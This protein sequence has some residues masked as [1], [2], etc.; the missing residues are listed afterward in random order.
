MHRELHLFHPVFSKVLCANFFFIVLEEI[1]VSLIQFNEE[2]IEIGPMHE[3]RSLTVKLLPNV[4]ESV[5]V[6]LLDR[7]VEC[8]S[9]S[10]ERV[11]NDSYEQ[12][13]E[14]LRNDDLVSN[15]VEL[16][17]L[18]ITASVSDEVVSGISFIRTVLFTLVSDRVRARGVKH[19][20]IPGF[21]SCASH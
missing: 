7:Q 13:K 6:Q 2:I 16:C 18:V 14:N 19:Q 1:C 12:I 15:E 21:S 3:S 8:T 17:K 4:D 11:H 20:L 5:N 9:L 10:D